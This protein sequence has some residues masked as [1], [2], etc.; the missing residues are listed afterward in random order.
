MRRYSLKGNKIYFDEE[1]FIDLNKQTIAEY[2]LQKRNEISEEEYYEIIRRRV[3][4]MGY[5]LL[6]KKDYPI[7]EFTTKLITK[8]REKEIVEEI[9]DEF[10][11]KG[12]LDDVEYGRCYIKL[13]IMGEK[14]WSLCFSRKDSLQIL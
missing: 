8:Y 6:S 5:F 4:S 11:E 13:T 3:L 7:K 14:K 9:I 12:Y 1:F 10:I 2:E